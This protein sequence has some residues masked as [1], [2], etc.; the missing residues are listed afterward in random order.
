MPVVIFCKEFCSFAVSSGAISW[1]EIND[2]FQ[3]IHG[4][5][6]RAF[7]TA[8]NEPK[9]VS[10]EQLVETNSAPA[11][12]AASSDPAVYSNCRDQGRGG[13]APGTKAPPSDPMRKLMTSVFD[14]A[15][16][17][18]SPAGNNVIYLGEDVRH[19]G[20]VIVFSMSLCLVSCVFI[21]ICLA[22]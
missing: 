22:A 15:L 19:G 7:N 21:F 4:S 11:I 8:V 16:G 13:A 2:E 18:Q 3:S 17:G 10:R 9:I 12:T 20:Y 1:S 6:E 14:E 5:I